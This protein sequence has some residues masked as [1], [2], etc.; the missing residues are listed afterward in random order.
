MDEKELEALLVHVSDDLQC[1]LRKSG[2]IF[3]SGRSTLMKGDFYLM[4]LNPG[5]DPAETNVVIEESLKK[6]QARQSDWSEYLDESWK[7]K[8][9]APHQ[10]RVHDFCEKLLRQDVRTIFSAN[11]LFVRTSK[12]GDLPRKGS[13][14]YETLLTDCLKVHRRLLSIV[15]PKIIVCLGN[16]PD[17]AFS[18]LKDWFKVLPKDVKDL[19]FQNPNRK[20]KFYIRWFDKPIKPESGQEFD[21]RVVGVPHPSWFDLRSKEFHMAWELLMPKIKTS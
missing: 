18:K 2:D 7:A 14:E 1:W 19:D 6:W 20:R 13:E 4:G 15:R 8:G 17:S 3:Y 21:C 10:M 5:G 16:G 9:K 11:I 12:G